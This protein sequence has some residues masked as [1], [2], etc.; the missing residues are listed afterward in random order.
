M[1]EQERAGIQ[2]GTR[3][4]N[5]G[6]SFQAQSICCNS[7]PEA[8]QLKRKLLAFFSAESSRTGQETDIG[9]QKQ[10]KDKPPQLPAHESRNGGAG[11]GPGGDS[12]KHSISKS[13]QQFPSSKHLL[14][15][16]ARDSTAQE[17]LLVFSSTV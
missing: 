14:Q 9:S 7:R 15:Q 17:E 3:S 5:R 10:L 11:A 12:D 13:G 1:A 6:S 2:T 8:E 4:R 16:S